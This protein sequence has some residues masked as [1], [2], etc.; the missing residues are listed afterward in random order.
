VIVG[1]ITILILG[2]VAAPVATK[3]RD[4]MPPKPT[5][6]ELKKPRRPSCESHRVVHKF[7]GI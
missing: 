1:V 6:I 4:T 3:S 7:N 5:S 2:L